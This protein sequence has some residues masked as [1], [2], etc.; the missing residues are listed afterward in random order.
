VNAL[1]YE[2][3]TLKVINFQFPTDARQSMTITTG[4]KTRFGQLQILNDNDNDKRC[5]FN[6]HKTKQNKIT[7]PAAVSSANNNAIIINLYKLFFNVKIPGKKI[8]KVE[9]FRLQHLGQIVAKR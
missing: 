9:L 2:I 1:R 4:P 5:L 6:I 7:K 8:F 3:I